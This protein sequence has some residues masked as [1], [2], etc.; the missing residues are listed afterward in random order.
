VSVREPG[1]EVQDAGGTGRPRRRGYWIPGAIALA[2]LVVLALAFGAG[3]LTHPAPRTL[4]G[5]DI[6]SEL[7]LGIQTQQRWASPPTL[8]C[9]GTVAVKEG[10]RF[11]CTLD[12]AGGP[13]P[14]DVV[15]V[16]GRGRLQWSLPPG[17][18]R[19][20]AAGGT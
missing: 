3:D 5:P 11:S 18:E 17:A 15:E 2:V 6:E 4:S 19:V 7:A 13:I 10:H 16:D 8:H 9:P 1:S 12:T 14:V 20:Q